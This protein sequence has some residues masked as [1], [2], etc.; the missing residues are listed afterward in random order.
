MTP[1]FLLSF[2]SILLAIIP[3]PKNKWNSFGLFHL[4]IK[5]HLQKL[6]KSLKAA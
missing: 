6:E 4:M 5:E 3:R 2:L 1:V